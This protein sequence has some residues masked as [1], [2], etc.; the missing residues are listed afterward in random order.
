MLSD[1]VIAVTLFSVNTFY[2]AA[3]LRTESNG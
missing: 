3:G 2:L 1:Q